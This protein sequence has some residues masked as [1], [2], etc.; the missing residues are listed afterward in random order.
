MVTH[1]HPAGS[2]T[3]R[4]TRIFP[5]SEAVMNAIKKFQP[6]IALFGHIHEAEGLEEMVGKTR[7]LNIG[8]EGKIIKI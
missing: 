6:D 8:R 1:V 7:L 5:G 2:K 4:M 3:E